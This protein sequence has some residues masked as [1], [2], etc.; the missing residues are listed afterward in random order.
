M[1]PSNRAE[2]LTTIHRTLKKHYNLTPP[3]MNLPLLEQLIFA[4]CLEE[5]PA[6]AAQAAYATLEEHFFDWNEV[7]VSTVS[8]LGDAMSMLPVPR[9]AATRVQH[10]LQSVFE[11]AYSFDLEALKKQNI[12]VAVKQ[13][14]KHH[15]VTSFGISYVTQTALGGHDIP[16]SPGALEVLFILGV[17][18]EKERL[19]KK[20]PGMERAIP[21]TKGLEF[22]ALLNHL[23]YEFTKSPH[24]PNVRKLILSIAPDAKERLPK[25]KTKAT[26]AKE[27]KAKAEAE[28]KAKEEK[29]AAEKAK[30]N[31]K[32]AAAAK[33]TPAKMAKKAAGKKAASK[34]TVK[35]KTVK[36]KTVTRKAAKKKTV[37]KKTVTKKAAK[38]KAPAK[39]SIKKKT[40]TKK[41][42]KRKPR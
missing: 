2:L 40:P 18:D 25:R 38:K 8:E 14:Q 42:T 36:K 20:V 37:K 31:K 26:E 34:K 4:C 28:K 35:K 29:A 21:K 22:G 11:S 6:D 24:S 10:A 7:R 27:A 23:A 32:K 33:K 19:A 12:G 13:L 5:A 39:K 9:G 30:A 41:I 16:V 15:G 17:I 1:P 3:A